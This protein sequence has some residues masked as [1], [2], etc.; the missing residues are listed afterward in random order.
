MNSPSIYWET[1]ATTAQERAQRERKYLL[2]D[3]SR[4]H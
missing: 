2:L 3:F 1:Q 4:E